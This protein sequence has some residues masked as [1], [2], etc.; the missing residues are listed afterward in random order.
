ME[1]D[2]FNLITPY[3]ARLNALHQR[4]ETKQGCLFLPLLF[5][6]IRKVQASIIWEENK[7]K[8]KEAG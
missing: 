2:F 1:G 3:S 7:I 6:I 5:K 8:G 4:S